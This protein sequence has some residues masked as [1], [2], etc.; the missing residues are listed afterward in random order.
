[1]SENIHSGH[2][3][4]LRDRFDK[5]GFEGWSDHEVLEFLLFSV[6]KRC[7][8]N[9]LA[10]RLI[11]AC[12]SLHGVLNASQE[13]LTSVHG[14]GTQAAY[15]LRTMGAA[16]TYMNN[17]V[18]NGLRLNKANTPKYLRRLFAG[19]KYECFYLLM[20]D[21]SMHLLSKKLLFEGE[22]SHA[23]INITEI[24]RATVRDDAAYVIAA[25]N[26]PSGV[27]APSEADISTTKII[28]EALAMVDASLV[29]HYIISGSECIG[30]LE[31]LEHTKKRRKKK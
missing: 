20:L 14:V 15:Y 3:K 31:Y 30:I 1:M 11:D 26:H 9:E 23:E 25:H 4:R 21:K 17:S 10:H 5:V 13:T 27:L 16:F 19:K 18:Q 28:R 12:G 2:R 22:F 24:F 29:E 7:D 8:T 6:F